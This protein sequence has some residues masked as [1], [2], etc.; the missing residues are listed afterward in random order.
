MPNIRIV[1]GKINGKSIK[2][3]DV[4]CNPTACTQFVDIQRRHPHLYIMEMQL[5]VHILNA[6]VR[7]CLAGSSANICIR[8]SSRL[9]N[10]CEDAITRDE[11]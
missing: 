11:M 9:R 10:C 1:G 7:L 8:N 4:E 3:F 6:R 2:M 5:G